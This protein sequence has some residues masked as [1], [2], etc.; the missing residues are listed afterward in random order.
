MSFE[1][2]GWLDVA[3]GACALSRRGHELIGSDRRGPGWQLM[4][5]KSTKGHEKGTGGC[6]PFDQTHEIALGPRCTEDTSTPY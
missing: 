1:V 2:R 5:T 6:F 4:A 3:A